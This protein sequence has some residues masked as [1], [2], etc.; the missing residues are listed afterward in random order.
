M[1]GEQQQVNVAGY[2]GPRRRA[3]LILL[4]LVNLL[5]LVGVLWLDWDVVGLLV[6]YWSENL[7][8]GFY[9]ILKMLTK[10]PRSGL[11]LSLFFCLH[12][13]G[14]CAGHGI[15]ILSVLLD[16]NVEPQSEHPWPLLLVFPQMFI[17]VVQQVMAHAPTDWTVPFVALVISHGVSFV[18]NFLLAGEREQVRLSELMAAPYSRIFLLH[19]AII[20]G[21]IAAMA[22]GQPLAMLV[23]LVLLKSGLD[24]KL[25]LREHRVLAK[26]AR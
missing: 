26:Q 3:S 9:T 14:F 1:P 4:L 7:I 16:V 17:N 12:Y 13:G 22:M 24:I 10:S 6:L 11:P 23:I 8:L 15:F 2:A 18:S 25:H 21:G 5:P 20:F 19:I